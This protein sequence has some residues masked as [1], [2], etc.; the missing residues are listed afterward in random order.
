[1]R[2]K[3]RWA[4]S[5]LVGAHARRRKARGAA[6]RSSK[7][8]RKRC[9]LSKRAKRESGPSDDVGKSA[10][11]DNGDATRQ[12]C[13][14]KPVGAGARSPVR[15]LFEIYRS[16]YVNA[17]SASCINTVVL[18]CRPAHLLSPHSLISPYSHQQCLLVALDMFV[19]APEAG[20]AVAALLAPARSPSAFPTRPPTSPPL[21]SSAPPSVPVAAASPCSP[22]TS[23]SQSP[24]PT[25]TTMMVRP[26]SALFVIVDAT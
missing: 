4:V 22:I 15:F 9:C 3:P 2:E 21:A 13:T 20:R 5:R 16:N 8:G 6:Q 10:Q 18:R 24:T 17:R 23:R 19:V 14:T 1:M 25:S 26:P 11:R 12:H 7:P